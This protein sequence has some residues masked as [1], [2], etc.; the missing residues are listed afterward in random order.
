MTFTQSIILICALVFS[1]VVVTD[2]LLANECSQPK[3]D[4][5]QSRLEVAQKL[6]D[7]DPAKQLK[8]KLLKGYIEDMVKRD[9]EK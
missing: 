9:A 1:I 5:W 7:T 2:K 8:I 6:P 4:Y 3:G